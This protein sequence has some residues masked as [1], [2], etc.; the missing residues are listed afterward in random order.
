[1]KKRL[2]FVFAV[3]SMYVANSPSA[4]AACQEDCRVRGIDVP[5]PTWS[6]PLRTCP[7][8]YDE[9][10]CV[11][12]KLACDGRLV[13]CVID[14][15]VSYGA[16]SSCVGMVVAAVKTGGSITPATALVCA[17]AAERIEA[18]IQHCR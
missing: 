5:C 1:M 9:P 18:T 2:A 12:R 4:L 15:M 7:S 14:A 11:A 6:E 13:S 8:Y 16:G 3:L 10:V 17:I